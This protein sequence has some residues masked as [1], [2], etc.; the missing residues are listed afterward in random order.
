MPLSQNTKTTTL[1][2]LSDNVLARKFPFRIHFFNETLC[3]NPFWRTLF[4]ILK[5]PTRN[6]PAVSAYTQAFKDALD[7]DGVAYSFGSG[8]MALYA[9][10]EAMNIGSGDEVIVPAFTCEV[11]ICA[12]L[13]RGITPVYADIEPYTFNID[14]AT[15]EKRITSKTRVIIAQHNFGVPCDMLSLLSIAKKHNLRLI[16][17]CAI[18]HGSTYAGKPVGTWGD[19]SF[20]STDRTKIISTQ[21]GGVAFT[22]RPAIA[23]KLAEFY[24]E[25]RFLP[26]NKILNIGLQVLLA[27]L[28]LTAR[29]YIWGKYVFSLGY[30]SGVFFDHTDDKATFTLPDDYPCRLSNL[31][32][33][34]GLRQLKSLDQ[35]LKI[36]RRMTKTY[37]TILRNNGIDLELPKDSTDKITL[38]FSFMLK[39]RA[40]FMKQ[41]EPYFEAGQ[42]FNEPVFGWDS[43]LRKIHYTPGSCP[44][45]EKVHNHIINFP[46]HQTSARARKLLYAILDGIRRDDL[47]APSDLLRSLNWH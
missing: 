18:A 14:V 3:Y 17:D 38:R 2:L 29:S 27:H 37:L 33:F 9:L 7:P 43:D 1:K 34:I 25:C 36:R 24:Q 26:Q 28:T 22:A 8:R 6:G 16:E 23:E 30:R 32:S 11:V 15:I 42:W 41:W 21:W 19:A 35:N 39:D 46:T 4:S 5:Q 40:A 31:Q 20:F 47:L 13:Y 44:V 45:A 12:L 10:L